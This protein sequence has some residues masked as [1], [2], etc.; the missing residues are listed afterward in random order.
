MD[1]YFQ[2]IVWVSLVAQIKNRP[3]MRET[4]VQFL[5]WEEPLEE[6]MATHF[7]ILA[8]RIPMDRGTW[9]VCPWG[10]KESDM[11]EQLSTQHT[12]REGR[13]RCRLKV[14]RAIMEYLGKSS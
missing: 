5:G 12:N 14:H 3:A 13:W 11:T 9:Q 6:G 4:W 7:S 1:V 2:L 8:W 10:C